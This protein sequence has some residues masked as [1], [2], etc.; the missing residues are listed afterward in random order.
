MPSCHGALRSCPDTRPHCAP[1]MQSAKAE[2]NSRDWARGRARTDVVPAA[3]CQRRSFPASGRARRPGATAQDSL[4]LA[5]PV[6]QLFGFA[7]V[8]LLLALRKPHVELDASLAVVQIEWN[9]GVSGALHLAD[10]AV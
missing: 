4:L 3:A 7:L 2:C 1:G 5:I 8:V 9:E 10:K 6:A